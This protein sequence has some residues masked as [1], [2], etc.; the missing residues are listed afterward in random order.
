MFLNIRS[1][2]GFLRTIV[3]INKVYAH[4]TPLLPVT[5]S[6]PIIP[7]FCQGRDSVLI[8]PS[9]T[10]SMFQRRNQIVPRL[11]YSS[12]FA[13]LYGDHEYPWHP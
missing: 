11:A 5:K 12:D 10:P 3:A 7:I 2:Q 8:P 6:E 4:V 1:S 9:F 13:G